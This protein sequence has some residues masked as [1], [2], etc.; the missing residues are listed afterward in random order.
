MQVPAHSSASVNKSRTAPQ[1]T[2]FSTILNTTPFQLFSHFFVFPSLLYFDCVYPYHV[3]I[4]Y[5]VLPCSSWINLFSCL[6]SSLVCSSSPSLLYSPCSIEFFI[7]LAIFAPA[8]LTALADCYWHP[9]IIPIHSSKPI[10]GPLGWQTNLP[11]PFE[12]FILSAN[13]STF[14]PSLCTSVMTPCGYDSDSFLIVPP[15]PS[16]TLPCTIIC[17]S[18]MYLKAMP[19]GWFLLLCM[20]HT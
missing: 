19:W 6:S 8:V 3:A 13:S 11:A 17:D 18:S 7:D 14:N 10:L 9:C 15:L 4:L 20:T 12:V 1:P 2:P 5:R 16:H